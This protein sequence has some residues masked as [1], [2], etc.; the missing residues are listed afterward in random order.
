MC[1][2][3]HTHAVRQLEGARPTGARDH[4]HS[5]AHA[6]GEM[7]ALTGLS[8]ELLEH[9]RGNIHHLDL[10]EGACCQCKQR[11]ADAVAF[12]VRLLPD[13]AERYER[14]GEMKGSRVVQAEVLA[15]IGEP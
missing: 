4:H 5:V 8:G 12:C 7:A 1:G 14:L 15:Q 13:I 9:W 2:S 11:T 10:V 3:H 6:H